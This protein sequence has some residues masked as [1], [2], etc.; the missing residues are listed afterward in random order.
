MVFRLGQLVRLKSG[1]PVMTVEGIKQMGVAYVICTWFDSTYMLHSTLFV[2]DVLT[3]VPVSEPET[4]GAPQTSHSK[5]DS[6]AA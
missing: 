2:H 6:S 1:G 4:A 5:T 3:P